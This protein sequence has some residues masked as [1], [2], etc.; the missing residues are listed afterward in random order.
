MARSK[1]IPGS[2]KNRTKPNGE[3]VDLGSAPSFSKTDRDAGAVENIAAETPTPG[4]TLAE[5]VAAESS[6]ISTTSVP[7]SGSDN[8]RFE[9]VKSEPRKN[10]V[11]IN[12]E[13]EIR[14]RAYELYEQRGTEAGNEAEDWFTAEREVKQRYRQQSA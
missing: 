6:R 8:R 13:D 5:K 4:D 11:P 12:L 7:Q 3:Q 1:S 9:V 14:R 10:L 2:K